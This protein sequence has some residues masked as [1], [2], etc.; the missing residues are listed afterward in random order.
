MS[1]ILLPIIV[2]LIVDGLVILGIVCE[3]KIFE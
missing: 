3:I 2:A 1:E